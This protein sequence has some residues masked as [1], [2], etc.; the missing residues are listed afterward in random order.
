MN[1]KSDILVTDDD[2]EMQSF[3]RILLE[4]HFN[5]T[6]AKDGQEAVD[7]ITAKRFLFVV[8]DFHLPHLTGLQVCEA[9]SGMADEQR[10]NVVMVSGESSD[11]V[12]CKA[13]D[14]GVD[15]YIV[16]P[17]CSIAFLQ[18][19]Q[20]LERDV[21][22]RHRLKDEQAKSMNLITS[23]MEQ[24]S[25][26]GSAFELI[27]R[28]NVASELQDAAS[29]VLRYFKQQG[30]FAAIQLRSPD[31]TVSADI[32][33]EECSAVELKVFQVLYDKGRIYNF[34]QRS[35]FNDENVSLLI[36][37]MPENTTSAYGFLVDIAAKLLPAINNRVTAIANEKIISGAVATL[38]DAI[39]M[40]GDGISRMESE[41]RQLMDEVATQ[42]GLSF[43]HLELT[44]DQEAFFVNL[45]EKQLKKQ[46]LGEEF[47]EVDSLIKD[48]LERIERTQRIAKET[49][50]T[51]SA[52]SSAET[53][54]FF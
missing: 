47:K 30:Y 17:F 10:P 12:V 22:E 18:R 49:L 7:L 45:I 13:Y 8:L 48:S 14:L 50:K 25:Q 6:I 27:S 29:E 44:E 15:D 1:S 33:T 34:G 4:P 20:R 41:K 2:P 19:L 16:K 31:N 36:K 52:S 9:I 32:D 26:Y 40:I 28:L 54:E 24:A 43:H 37:N 46:S 42:I 5:V 38:S 53:V 3:M 39:Q 51:E 11:E 35:I 21:S 23:A